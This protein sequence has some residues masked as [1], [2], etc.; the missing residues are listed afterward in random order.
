MEEVL[1]I[2]ESPFV[3]NLDRIAQAVSWFDLAMLFNLLQQERVTVISETRTKILPINKLTGPI[4]IQRDGVTYPPF[5]FRDGF[6]LDGITEL[7][8]DELKANFF[9]DGMVYYMTKEK[10]MCVRKQ[11]TAYFSPYKVVRNGTPESNLRI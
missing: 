2:C 11:P 8:L 10:Y 6:R 5:L 7:T 4:C 3:F 1:F 9:E